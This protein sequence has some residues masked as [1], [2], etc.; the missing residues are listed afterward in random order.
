MSFQKNKFTFGMNSSFQ[1]KNIFE[2]KPK[3]KNIFEE[4]DD[5]SSPPPIKKKFT[6]DDDDDDNFLEKKFGSK[7]NTKKETVKAE[8]EEKKR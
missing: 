1:N 4:E 5:S 6:L 2:N 8:V 3:R 7:I